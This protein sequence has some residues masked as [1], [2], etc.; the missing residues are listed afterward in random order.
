MF[1]RMFSISAL[2]LA[3]IFAAAA[4]GASTVSAEI[5]DV[6]DL[7]HKGIVPGETAGNG[8]LKI[9]GEHKKIREN[10]DKTKSYIYET[11][12]V[13]YPNELTLNSGGAVVHM[14]ITADASSEVAIA[15]IKKII[16]E[17]E[18]MG[19]SMYAFYYRVH[20]YPKLGMAFIC[21]EKG[22]LV[23]TQ[24]FEKCDLKT[25]EERWGKNFPKENPY[26]Q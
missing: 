7:Y 16:G 22:K 17:P 13:N 18:R 12:N 19:F 24:Y 5:M 10:P 25:F 14:A 1:L 15:Q 3:V 20:I 23:E 6:K 8:A 2:A 4:S 9:M 26:K 21:E 11:A